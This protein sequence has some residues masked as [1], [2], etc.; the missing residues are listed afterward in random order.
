MSHR[1]AL[2]FAALTAGL[3]AAFGAQAQLFK[4][5]T[6]GGRVVYQDSPCA[7][8]DKQTAIRAPAAAPAPAPSGAPASAKAPAGAAAPASAPASNSVETV[9]G[10][11][12]CAERVPNF[13]RKYAG[14]YEDWKVRNAGALDRLSVEPDASRLDARLREERARAASESIA[15]RCADVATSLQAPR[16]AAK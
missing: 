15:E 3:L 6:S 4:C 9:A 5:V 13:E 1:H 16:A 7:D 10:Y 12:V 14:A 8:A 11:T 2:R